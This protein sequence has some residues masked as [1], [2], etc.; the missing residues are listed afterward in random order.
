[1]YIVQ[2]HTNSKQEVGS[3]DTD[4][5]TDNS[6]RRYWVMKAWMILGLTMPFRMVGKTIKPVS[7]FGTIGFE[8]SLRPSFSVAAE[9]AF[10]M[11]ENIVNAKRSCVLSDNVN[12]LVDL[13]SNLQIK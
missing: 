9:L 3:Y 5:H 1:M 2:P 10:S 12:M 4:S 7:M 8:I 13:A 11:V 6:Y